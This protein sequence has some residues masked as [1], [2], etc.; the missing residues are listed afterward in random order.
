MSAAAGTIEVRGPH[1]P[2]R[3]YWRAALVLAGLVAVLSLVG[4][5]SEQPAKG[6]PSSDGNASLDPGPT[7]LAYG[8]EALSAG[9][10]VLDLDARGS[11]DERFPLI[12]ITVPDGWANVDGWAVNSG[13]GSD[14]WVG[15]TFWDVDEVYAHPCQW[16]GR[17]I[18]PGPTVADLAE[19]LAKH[20]LR[21]ATKPVDIVVDG[22]QGM[23]VEWSVPA[24]IDFSTCDEHEGEGS[25]ESWTA[26]A[27]SWAGG[28]SQQG[29]RRST[30]CG[31]SIS[32]ASD[33]WSTRCTCPDRCQRSRGALAGH[34]VDLLRD[35]ASGGLA[36]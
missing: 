19:A 30:G 4:C 31:S 9:T 3:L 22:F 7:T 6:S 33:S 24:G 8:S 15:M 12:T 32:T 14:H 25:F 29:R 5:S 34:G 35:V 26:A 13:E 17:R 10:Y 23:Q 16:Q 21:D 11:G 18:Q 2:V 36:R 28:R 20:P 27:D 1:R